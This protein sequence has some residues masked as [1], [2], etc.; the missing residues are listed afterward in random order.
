M[1]L[2]YKAAVFFVCLS[3]PPLFF[4][5]DRRIATKFGTH[6]RVDMGPILSKKI[7]PAHP[8]GNITSYVTSSNVEFLNASHTRRSMSSHMTCYYPWG[9]LDQ[10]FCPNPLYDA[11]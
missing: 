1:Y 11:L 6:I 3:V 2:L 10:L 4:R 9:G 5:H 7:D 8:R